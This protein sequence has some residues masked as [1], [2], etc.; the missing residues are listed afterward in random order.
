MVGVF[1]VPRFPSDTRLG[2]SKR[3][4]N[5][6]RWEKLRSNAEISRN[7]QRSQEKR[8]RSRECKVRGGD[9]TFG[10]PLQEVVSL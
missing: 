7:R 3:A 9:R 10:S 2:S 1:N 4:G 6:I 8:S 5:G